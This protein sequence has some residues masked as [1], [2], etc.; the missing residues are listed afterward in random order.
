MNKTHIRVRNN[1]KKRL[2]INRIIIALI[3][4]FFIIFLFFYGLYQLVK[5]IFFN[6]KENIEQ[7]YS[8]STQDISDTS[9]KTSNENLDSWELILVNKDN[10]LNNNYEPVE[11]TTTNEGV[12]IDSRIYESYLKMTKDAQ[13]D[14][15][16]FWATSGYRSYKSQMTL[17]EQQIDIV[18]EQNPNYTK[19]QAENEASNTVTI[20]GASEHQTG[21]AIDIV[22]NEYNQLEEAAENT[23][24]GK[25][26]M[27]NCYKYGFI[28]RYPKG[29]EDITKIIYEPWHY[30][31]VGVEAATEIMLSGITLEEYIAN[32]KNQ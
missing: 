29:K 20:P 12:Q 19:K 27:E 23:K 3:I 17:Y 8:Y 7:N 4:L 21:L 26:L 30:R 10:L 9:N 31:Y 6:Q 25:W 28:L 2:L 11:L 22:S 1:I 13:E 16:P 5:I 15:A 14:G 32:I 24:A 18:M